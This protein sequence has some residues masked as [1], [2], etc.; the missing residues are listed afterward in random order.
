[1]DYEKAFAA[2]YEHL[3]KNPK[4]AVPFLV[5]FIVLFFTIYVFLVT[6]GFYGFLI[7]LSDLQAKENQQNYE[8]FHNQTKNQSSFF[9]KI[10]DSMIIKQMSKSEIKVEN[11]NDKDFEKE[12]KNIFKPPIITYSIGFGLFLLLLS[13]YFCCIYYSTIWLS[14]TKKNYGFASSFGFANKMFWKYIL[15][16]LIVLSI[17]LIFLILIIGIG[18]LA[19]FGI[20]SAI[21][22]FLA[23]LV[24]LAFVLFSIWFFIYILVKLYFAVIILFSE[25]LSPVQSIKK[26]FSVSRGNFKTVLIL[27]GI[28][29]GI[30]FVSRSAG[31]SPVF[32]SFMALIFAKNILTSIALLIVIAIFLITGSLISAFLIVFQ[33]HSYIFFKKHLKR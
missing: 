27:F 26:S 14:I 9:L 20:F 32:S 3:K 1:M 28:T 6:S 21:N 17:F 2:S 29:V 12:V 33:F 4:I 30:S 24:V 25:S 10:I 23:I 7:H 19:F 22:I 16:S 13:W 31:I 15:T 5:Y 11:M 8:A 18:A